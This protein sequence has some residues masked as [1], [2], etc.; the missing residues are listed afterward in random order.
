MSTVLEADISVHALIV[1]K[2]LDIREKY[3]KK[4]DM[5]DITNAAIKCGID[6][7][8]EELGLIKNEHK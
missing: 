4:I 1:R 3:G 7:V 2:K 6:K 8:E 5:V